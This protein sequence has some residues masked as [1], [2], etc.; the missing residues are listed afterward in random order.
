[1]TVA[2]V[3][4]AFLDSEQYSSNSILHYE[5]VYGE[6]FVSPGGRTMARELIA[7]LGLKEGS[8]VL[9]VG[10]GLGGSAFLM[11]REFGLKVDG[12]DLSA[13]M[14][15]MARS[16]LKAHKIEDRVCLE[17]GDCLEINRQRSYDG[18]YS[19]DVFLHIQDK[20]RLFKMLHSVLRP[21]G[22]LLFTDYCCSEKPWSEGFARYVEDRSYSLNTLP[23]YSEIISDAGFGDVQ[24]S[25]WTDRFIDILRSDLQTISGLEIEDAARQ[26]L[27]QGWREKLARAESGFHKWGLFTAIRE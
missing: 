15:E 27:E 16:K 18:I 22:R 20:V 23:E 8:K 12:V 5:A 13:N 19:R 24:C 11:A 6:D 25:D 10:C 4:Q 1:M 14:I 9:D 3:T 21:Q 17:L 7:K 2:E 26:K